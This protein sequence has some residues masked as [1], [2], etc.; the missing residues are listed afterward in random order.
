MLIANSD[1]RKHIEQ[2]K[3]LTCLFTNYTRILPLVKKKTKKTSVYS[4]IQTATFMGCPARQGIER[5][6]WSKL[7]KQDLQ[8][9][10]AGILRLINQN[11]K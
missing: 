5:L 11:L 9:R 2:E 3:G 7:R 1:R 10:N 6:H 4:S 8:A